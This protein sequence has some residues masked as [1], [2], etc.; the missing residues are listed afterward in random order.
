MAPSS[1]PVFW[2]TSVSECYHQQQCFSG[3]KFKS[4]LETLTI[5]TSMPISHQI[6]TIFPLSSSQMH[7]S[8]P[9]FEFLN[10]KLSPCF[11]RLFP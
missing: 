11:D 8:H 7:P 5:K 1:Q 6:L 4:I 10:F 9:Y 2:Y 3:Q